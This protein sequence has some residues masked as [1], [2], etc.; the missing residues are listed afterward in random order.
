MHIY[1][2]IYILIVY[3]H[4]YIYMYK[5]T[6]LIGPSSAAWPP[7]YRL[8]WATARLGEVRAPLHPRG[9]SFTL[10]MLAPKGWTGSFYELEVLLEGCRG[11]LQGFGVDPHKN[12]IA[13]STNWGAFFWEGP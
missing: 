2:Y 13:V 7:A 6:Y 3:I 11:P 1:I 5:Y 4:I 12:Y 8:L 10:R 9:W